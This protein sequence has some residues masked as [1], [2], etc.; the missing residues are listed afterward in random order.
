MR[1]RDIKPAFAIAVMLM[2]AF[3][4]RGDAQSL[5]GAPRDSRFETRA[6][7][8]LEARKALSEHR[9]PEAAVVHTRIQEGDFQEGDR[10]ILAI[11]IP[12]VLMPD[13]SNM[14]A[15]GGV[16]TAVVR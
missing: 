14:L 4:Q 16:D 8:E 1:N 10:I 12:R 7:L 11:D 3:G 2:L 13:N 6:Q 9:D 5:A 15:L